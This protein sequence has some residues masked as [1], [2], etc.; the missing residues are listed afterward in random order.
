MG[1]TMGAISRLISRPLQGNSARARPTAAS[2][3]RA[4]AIT[5]AAGATMALLRD[6][7]A[8]SADSNRWRYHLRDQ[9]GMGET[10][11]ELPENDSGT[12]TRMGASKNPKSTTHSAR[13]SHQAILSASVA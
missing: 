7:R 6:A 5:V 10:K 12:I 4:V 9:P 2:V 3:P 1:T 11:K 13:S 8:H